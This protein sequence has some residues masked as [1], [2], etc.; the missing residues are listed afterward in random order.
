MYIDMEDN[1]PFT[2]TGNLKNFCIGLDRI[3]IQNNVIVIFDNDAAGCSSY[4]AIKGKCNTSNLL[5]LKLPDYDS[6]TSFE[7]IG[8]QGISNENINGR[9]VAIECFLDFESVNIPT[10]IR[11]KSYDDR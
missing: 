8:P 7:T 11:W 1:Y 5:I 9:A 6:F 4:N 2:G 10:R 3:K